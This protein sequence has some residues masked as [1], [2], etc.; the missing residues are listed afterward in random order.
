MKISNTTLTVLRNFSTI[1]PS[2]NVDEAKCLKV[3]SQ[4]KNIIA[5]FDTEEE[6]EEFA[7]YDMIQLL[8][9]ISLFDLEKTDF[10]FKNYSSG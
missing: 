2:I 8:G 4:S 1:T 9:I 7:I 10:I 6:F 3:M 5:L